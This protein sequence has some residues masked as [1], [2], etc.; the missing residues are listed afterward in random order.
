MAHRVLSV[1]AV[2]VH[3]GVS[4]AFADVDIK[5]QD[6][7]GYLIVTP[8]YT[9]RLGGNGYLQSVRAGDVE[10]LQTPTPFGT[11]T[12]IAASVPPGNISRL[13]DGIEVL[14]MHKVDWDQAKKTIVATGNEVRVTYEFR[15]EDIFIKPRMTVA[16]RLYFFL[17]PSENVVRSLDGLT[18][19]SVSLT[20]GDVRAMSQEGMRLGH[21]PGGGVP[22]RRRHRA[23]KQQWLRQ[24]LLVDRRQSQATGGHDP[25][26]RIR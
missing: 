20:E 24:L 22:V 4:T 26:A 17:F 9:A 18:D 14:K 15:N 25:G 19:F 2:L 21:S 5:S 16:K 11:A 6:D 23:R 10:M 8:N 1:L 7:G 3:F 13:S 12:F